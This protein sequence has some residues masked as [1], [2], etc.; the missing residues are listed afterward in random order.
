MFSSLYLIP[1]F[2]LLQ[3][4][5]LDSLKLLGTFQMLLCLLLAYVGNWASVHKRTHAKRYYYINTLW[6]GATFKHVIATY[7]EYREGMTWRKVGK[8][9]RSSRSR[10]SHNRIRISKIIDWLEQRLGLYSVKSQIGNILGF[11]DQEENSRILCKCLYNKK[12]ENKCSQ[13]LYWWN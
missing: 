11:A 3:I 10:E 4:L 2:S 8:E 1:I 5:D 13:N 12:R 7:V 9:E 6:A